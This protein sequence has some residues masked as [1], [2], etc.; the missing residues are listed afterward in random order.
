MR[1]LLGIVALAV[2]LAG[3]AEKPRVAPK[4]EPLVGAAFW[5]LPPDQPRYAYAGTLTGENDFRPKGDEVQKTTGQ[6]IVEVI[7]GFIFGDAIPVELQ[8]P[9]SGMTDAQ[10]RVYVADAGQQAVMVF[11]MQA[12]RLRRWAFAADDADFLS[13]VAVVPDGAGGIYVTD[14]LLGAIVHLD[15][16]GKPLGMIGKEFLQRPT[17]LARDVATGLLYVTDTQR[18]QVLVVSPEGELLDTIGHRGN[19]VGEF[20]FPT[21]LTI[22][23]DDLYVADSLNF[24]IQVF[25]LKGDG[26]LTFGR[27]GLNV[28]DMARPKGVGVGGDGRIYVVES[29]YDHLLIFNPLGEL[30]LAI[31]G[32]GLGEGQFYLPS[33]VW[34]DGRGRVYVA[35]MFNGRVAVFQELTRGLDG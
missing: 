6:R 22:A 23:G 16:D 17:G 4:L 34:T 13:P 12:K 33:G 7:T 2:A 1:R 19:G 28:G 9:V 21:H 32:T 30:L 26:K 20:N 27:V 31:G 18:H 5:P 25:T 11:D 15:R 29:Y 3:C 8:R 14:S 24:R 35:D 10:G